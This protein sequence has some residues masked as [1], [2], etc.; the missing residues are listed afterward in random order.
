MNSPRRSDTESNIYE[1]SLNDRRAAAQRDEQDRIAARQKNLAAQ[2]S[3]H[4]DPSQR[5]RLWEHLHAMHLPRDAKHRL[6]HVIA[7]QTALTVEQIQQEQVR[8]AAAVSSA[9]PATSSL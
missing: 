8:R 4:A 2:A 6:I 9:P 3:P 5:I 1:G 7:A